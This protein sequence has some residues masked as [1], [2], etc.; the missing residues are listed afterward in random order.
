MRP[1]ALLLLCG[2]ASA[3]LR[4]EVALTQTAVSADVIDDGDRIADHADS[5][6]GL[7]SLKA[8][9]QLPDDCT[10]LARYA[11]SR[12]GHEL[13]PT[14]GTRGTNGVTAIWHAAK[15]KKALHK[16][17]PEPG[18]LVFFKETY[19]RDRD[20]RRDDGLTHIGVVESIEADGTVVFVHRSGRGVTKERL[21]T[22]RPKDT[23]VNDWLRTRSRAGPAALTGELFAGYASW[24]AMLGGR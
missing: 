22:R 11:Y 10:G 20:G 7:Q 3:P 19:D 16:R 8:V 14:E 18:D 24:D 1:V 17:T 13:M 4:D 21:N 23:S 2:C 9:T 5:L 6:V 12:Q 15:Q